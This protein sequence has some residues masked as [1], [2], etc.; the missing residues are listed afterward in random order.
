MSW[1]HVSQLPELGAIDVSKSSENTAKRGEMIWLEEN[2]K[3]RDLC[4]LPRVSLN[5]RPKW[6]K[7]RIGP[8]C[9]VGALQDTDVSQRKNDSHSC[10]ALVPKTKG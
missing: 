5:G 2:S 10:I 4:S 1:L 8:Q 7:D 3:S 9:T 6:G